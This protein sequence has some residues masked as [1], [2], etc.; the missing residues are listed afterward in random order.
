MRCFAGVCVTSLL[1]LAIAVGATAQASPEA[2][3]PVDAPQDAIMASHDEIQQMHN[4][5]GGAFLGT[6]QPPQFLGTGV[7]FS[8]R[9]GGAD[10]RQ[11]MKTWKHATE[12]KQ[13]DACDRHTATWNDPATGLQVQAKITV[14]KRYP[15][16]DWV[17]Y[18]ENTG[19]KDTPI[20][21]DIRTLDVNLQTDD[22]KKTAVLHQLVG[23]YCF[24]QSFQPFDTE[25]TAGK[26]LSLAP[27]GG[28]PSNRTFPFFN[29]EYAG[30]GLIAAI[31]WSGQWA[32][33]LDR[34]GEGLT[35]L[36]A[37]M[38]KTHLVL[39]PGERIRSPRILLMSW[40]ADRQAAQ[41]RF[42]RLLMFQYVPKQ[43]G[44]PWRQ[45]FAAEW[46]DRYRMKPGFATEAG[47][48]NAA[49]AAHD[50]GCD[51]YWIDALWFQGDFPG[52]VGNWYP[53]P[54]DFPNGLKPIGDAC[55]RMG[56][57]FM[58][59]FEPERVVKGTQIA[60]EHPEFVIGGKEGGLFKLNDPAARR[61]LTDLLSKRITEYGIDI[62]RNDFNITPLDYWRRSDS[63]DRQ[64]ITEIRYVEGHY[65]MWDELMARHPGLMIDNCASGGRRIDLEACMRSMPLS[66]SD[67]VCVA[68][69]EEWDQSQTQ[70]LSLYIPLSGTFPWSPDAYVMRSGA[71]AGTCC[72]FGFLDKGFSTEQAKAALAEA[73]ENQKY[74]Y[75]DFYPLTPATTATDVWA[76]YQLHRPDLNAGLVLAFRRSGCPRE[77][78]SIKLGAINPAANYSVERIDEARQSRRETLSGRQLSDP[79]ELRLEKKATS[80]LLRYRKAP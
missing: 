68:G 56:M 75:G 26:S 30:R 53:K 42:R 45:P 66:R 40:Q 73:K 74:W 11:A 39:H 28:R 8:F 25:L 2:D 60:Q 33:S 71:T 22:A 43:N 38:Q 37:G 55:H 9:Y 36:R 34:N 64:G 62:Y 19:N 67:T 15:A 58:L 32:A 5:A 51:T 70:G 3:I 4:W 21:E 78:Q 69:H 12:V 63:P 18:F 17:L 6:Q 20:L 47:Q 61:W 54:K 24:Q 72:Q 31:G 48:L 76:A 29:F 14:W 16:L 59:W 44:R 79:Q 1:W 57:K 13:E 50:F 41:Q 35:R 65:A 77:T 52:G 27:E 49:K 23:D 80:L 46:F 7:P 10:S